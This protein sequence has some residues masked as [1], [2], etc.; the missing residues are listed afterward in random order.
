MPRT[1]PEQCRAARRP[2]FTNA[3]SRFWVGQTV[4]M[5]GGQIGAFAIPLVAILLLH[6]SALEVG[7]LYGLGYLPY[8]FLSAP[9]G[10]LVD[11]TSRHRL[12]LW[13]DTARSLT[14]GGIA[15]LLF[16][17]DLSIASLF[18][19]ETALGVLNVAFDSA[20]WP[21]VSE[22]STTAN[23]TRDSSRI[24]ASNSASGMVGPAIGG[25]L[26][27]AVGA[28]V[29]VLT[30]GLGCLAS[31]MTLLTVPADRPPDRPAALGTR[32]FGA[33]LREGYRAV[34][35]DRLLTALAIEA[36]W[37]NCAMYIVS[38]LLILYAIA[39]LGLTP[40][41]IGIVLVGDSI[42]L[43]VGSLLSPSLERALGRRKVLLYGMPLSTVGLFAVALAGGPPVFAAVEVMGGLGIC[44]LGS[45]VINPVT[46]AIRQERFERRFKGR[47]FAFYRMV[48]YGGTAI[49][50]LVGGVL[51]T[52]YGLRP[53]MLI[54]ASLL[55][56]A[57]IPALI[58]IARGWDA[59]PTP[60][61]RAEGESLPEGD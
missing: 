50:P 43:L 45:G 56:L 32:S 8:L 61:R 44:G 60:S 14:F 11:R 21:Y 28:G 10:V 4:S 51:G 40:V 46:I 22:L 58:A 54:G 9:F 25:A 36:G 12:L 34:F 15:I 27:E 1:S 24:V 57:S 31:V 47:G 37:Y 19:A 3:F 6:A 13:T 20:F 48:G 38:A 39:D 53:T 2:D 18:A 33:E 17:H 55:A 42:A 7:V 5:L 29:T 52:A 41:V 26:V 16:G 35:H 23:S 30:N 49:G 59:L